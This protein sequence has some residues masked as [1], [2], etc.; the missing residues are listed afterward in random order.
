MSLI[1]TTKS[2]TITVPEG[3][4]VGI[5]V[6]AAEGVEGVRVRRRRTV[7]VEARVVRLAVATRR[8]EP[9]VELAEQAQEAIASALKTMC[10]I[11][12]KVDIAVSE[13]E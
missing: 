2:G 6:R 11:D 1:L 7:D 13:L 12:A 5:A 4:L 10:G 9:V 3:V 8:G